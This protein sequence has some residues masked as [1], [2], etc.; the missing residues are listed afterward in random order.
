MVKILIILL[1]AYLMAGLL[2]FFKQRDLLYF[3]TAE[4]HTTQAQALWLDSDHNRLKIWKINNHQRAVIYFGGNAEA[5]EANITQFKELLPGYSI[6][7]VNYRGYGGSSGSP[8]EQALFA[9]ALAVFDSISHQHGTVSVIGR[10][11][12]TGVALYLANQRPVDRV[13]LITPYDSI[14]NV[15]KSHYPSYPV[16]WFLKD[17]FDSIQHSQ[18][19]T[20]PTL[21]LTAANDQIIPAKNSQNLIAHLQQAPL[22]QVSIAASNHNDISLHAEYAAAIT[23]FMR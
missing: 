3:P 20:Q 13:V 6:Y 5:V 16:G 7:L 19:L 22:Q 2:L 15:A 21:V 17:R 9:D 11:L 12:G 4:S 8:S 14:V 1:V 10:S 23:R 18:G